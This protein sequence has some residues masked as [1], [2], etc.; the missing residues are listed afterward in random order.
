MWTIIGTHTFNKWTH[1]YSPFANGQLQ[2]QS[3]NKLF[4]L[5]LSLSLAQFKFYILNTYYYFYVNVLCVYINKYI[6]F[7]SWKQIT[8]FLRAYAC[9]YAYMCVREL[10]NIFFLSVWFGLLYWSQKWWSF[11]LICF[12]YKCWFSCFRPSLLLLLWMIVYWQ[13]STLTL[14]H[15]HTHRTAQTQTHPIWLWN[16]KTLL[17]FLIWKF[18]CL[19]C[20]CENSRKTGNRV[21]ILYVNGVCDKKTQRL[22]YSG[23]NKIYQ[24][25]IVEFF[26]LLKIHAQFGVIL[27]EHSVEL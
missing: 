17:L 6:H 21:R 23:R 11:R 1:S 24:I 26:L 10:F 4:I 19:F 27:A 20:C 14:I 9:A 22:G 16:Y 13:W 2:K 8:I 25:H 18:A 12:D 5:S 3:H 15:T 7:I